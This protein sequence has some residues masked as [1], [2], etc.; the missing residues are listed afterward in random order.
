MIALE[1]GEHVVHRSDRDCSLV[2]PEKDRLEL[3]TVSD[4]D[5]A[6]RE[7]GLKFNKVDGCP[8]CMPENNESSDANAINAAVAA[9]ITVSNM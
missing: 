9:L 7:A 1:S 4:D 3:G 8:K 5:E 6:I 2:P